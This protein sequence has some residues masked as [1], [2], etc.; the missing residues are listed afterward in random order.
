MKLSRFIIL[1]LIL[2]TS[3]VAMDLIL[4]QWSVQAQTQED[5]NVI[6]RWAFAAQVKTD[7]GKLQAI[8]QD[9][10]LHTG[11]QLKIALELQKPCFVY[12][13]YHGSQGEIQWLFPASKQAFEQGYRS[14]QRYDVPTG[15]AWFQLN[16]QTGRETFYLL[17][18]VQ[19]LPELEELLESYVKT[20]AAEQPALASRIV[21]DIRA[22]RKRHQQFTALAE[23]P[24]PIAGNMRTPNGERLGQLAV[25]IKAQ[26]FYSKT[27]TIEH[28]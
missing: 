19:R 21:T 26:D 25:E 9:T 2:S 18:S 6:F 14:G 28:R 24:V 8:T 13:V 1:A 16:D 20:P 4:P 3:L 22:L 27:Y 5:A 23:R 7:N 10:E 11:D 15:D 17:A 12:V